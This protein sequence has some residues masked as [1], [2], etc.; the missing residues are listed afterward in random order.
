[1]SNNYVAMEK[2][3]CPVCGE[4]HEHNTGILIHKKLKD[5]PK[6]ETVTGYGLCKSCDDLTEEYIALVAIDP[7]QSNINADRV[8]NLSD[9]YRTG[10]IMHVR[11][12]VIPQIFNT[13]VDPELPLLFVEEDV[14]TKLKEMM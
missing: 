10:S 1:M 4:V 5:I 14:I 7:T 2:N 3:V 12:S 11:R 9:V 13:E 6:D 8:K